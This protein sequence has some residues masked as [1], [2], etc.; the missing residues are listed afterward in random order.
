MLARSSTSPGIGITPG[1]FVPPP[2][3]AQSHLLCIATR[4]TAPLLSAGAHFAVYLHPGFP[5]PRAMVITRMV[6]KTSA[7]ATQSVLPST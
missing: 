3:H 2:P 1:R 4:E 6:A 7:S 5:S